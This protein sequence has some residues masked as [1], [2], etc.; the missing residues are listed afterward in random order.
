VRRLALGGDG[1]L[2]SGPTTEREKLTIGSR[3][4][5]NSRIKNT[6]ETKIAQKIAIR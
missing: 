4:T 2:M 3:V 5:D 6:P 1:A